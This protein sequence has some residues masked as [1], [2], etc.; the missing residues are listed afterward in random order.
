[1]AFFFFKHHLALRASLCPWIL[2]FQPGNLLSWQ[3][4]LPSPSPCWCW[5]KPEVGFSSGRKFIWQNFPSPS[6]LITGEVRRRPAPL[7]SCSV[8]LFFFPQSFGTPPSAPL[9]A[10]GFL[11]SVSCVRRLRIVFLIALFP[12]PSLSFL[13]PLK[14]GDDCYITVLQE[15]LHSRRR[16][17][18]RNTVFCN[19]CEKSNPGGQ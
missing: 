9:V 18:A 13:D 14:E 2:L 15:T 19:L 10:S 6:L 17:P 7:T 5:E 3:P 4:Q 16:D 11:D 8:V 12:S 1:M